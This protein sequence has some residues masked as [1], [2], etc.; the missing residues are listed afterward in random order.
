MRLAE[1]A[2]KL[3]AEKSQS[4]WNERLQ[5]MRE[6]KVEFGHCRVPRKY[7]ANPKL[8]HWVNTQ[9]YN[10]KLPKEGKPSLMTAERSRELESI[11]FDWGT[12]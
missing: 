9:R 8:G 3:V 1:A 4:L 12:S 5:Q 2:R 10:Y 7:A 6:F 11:G